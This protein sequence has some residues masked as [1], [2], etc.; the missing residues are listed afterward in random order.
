MANK[1]FL[2][3]MGYTKQLENEA[4]S[5][6]QESF[7]VSADRFGT[8][9]DRLI[10]EAEAF[11]RG[12]MDIRGIQKKPVADIFPYEDSFVWYLVVVKTEYVDADTEKSKKKNMQYLV[13]AGSVKQAFDRILENLQ[14]FN[15]IE[16]TKTSATTIEEIFWPD[17]ADIEKK[18]AESESTR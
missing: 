2:I 13:Q 18:I 7:M 9:E 5:R 14:E 15:N 1:W 16:V 8:A 4:F 17:E 6:V 10:K 3:R 12:E 11:V